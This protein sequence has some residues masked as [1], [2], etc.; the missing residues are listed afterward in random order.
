MLTATTLVPQSET[1]VHCYIDCAP[2]QMP[3]ILLV[4]KFE[5]RLLS[6]HLSVTPGIVQPHYG[7]FSLLVANPTNMPIVLPKRMTLGIATPVEDHESHLIENDIPTKLTSDIL[8]K[9]HFQPDPAYTIDLSRCQISDFQRDQLAHL[10][11]TFSDIFSRNQYDLG[12]CDVIKHKMTTTTNTPVTMRPTRVPHK[13]KQELNTQISNLIRAGVLKESNTNWLANLVFVQK[14][15]GTFRMCV[16]YRKL[17]AVT[18]NDIFPLPRID[19]ILER[20]GNCEYYTRLDLSQGFLQIKISEEMSNK[21]GIIVEDKCYQYTHLP[22]GLKNATSIFCRTMAQVLDGLQD[23]VCFYVDDVLIFTRSPDFDCHLHALRQVFQRFRKFNLKLSPH[24]CSFAMRTLD[25]LGHTLTKRGYTPGP[26]KLEAIKN[27]PIPQTVQQVRRFIGLAGFYRRFIPAFAKLSAPLTELTKKN[28]RFEWNSLRQLAFTELKRLLLCH[29]VLIFP[30]YDKDFHIFTDCSAIA[31]AGALMQ[32]ADG[33]KNSYQAISYCSRTLSDSERR[34]PIIQA[35]LATIVFALRAFKAYIFMTQCIVHTDHKPL[36]YVLKKPSAHPNLARW[37]IELQSYKVKIEFIK[38]EQN[39]VADAL[40]RIEDPNTTTVN[41]KDLD[42]IIDFPRCFSIPSANAIQHTPLFSIPVGHKFPVRTTTAHDHFLDMP[43]EQRKDPELKSIIDYLMSHALPPHMSL[44]ETQKFEQEANKY[45]IDTNGC[46]RITLESPKDGRQSRHCTPIVVPRSLRPLVFD[47]F[48]LSPLAGGH[49]S[50]KKVLHKA[51]PYYWP[52][53]ATDLYHWTK[54]CT[55]CQMRNNPKP[56]PHVPLFP[57]TSMAV[58]TNVGLDLC[59]P[60]TMTTKGHKYILNIICM[61]TKYVISIPVED[62]RSTTIAHAILTRCL[63]VYG[64]PSILLSD[65]AT[66][67]SSTFFQEF[68]N[69]LYIN[70]RYCTPYHSAGNG[71]VERTF[72]TFQNMLAKYITNQNSDFDEFLPFMTFCYN[73]SVNEMTGESPYFLMF[74]RDPRFAIE[75]V[76]KFQ[77]VPS[78]SEIDIDEY[79]NGLI[80][81][82]RLAWNIAHQYNLQAQARM[83]AIYDRKAQASKIKIGDRVL[84][85]RENVKPGHSKKFHLPWTGVYR[86]IDIRT[87]NA[88]LVSCTTPH[89]DP[90]KVHLNQIKKFYAI[91]GPACSLPTIPEEDKLALARLDAKSI[92]NMPGYSHP[93]ISEGQHPPQISSP[94]PDVPKSPYNLR[95]R[96]RNVDS[97]TKDP[98]SSPDSL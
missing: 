22:F 90:F 27:F 34:W 36:A 97:T 77:H 43:T 96:L 58:F 19:T 81:S 60:F 65:N 28:C 41:T 33:S 7:I 51:A 6:H 52:S 5:A 21:L 55:T 45:H 10:I 63:L 4:D 38:G 31:Q 3:S 79:K 69:L 91:D 50:F 84:L 8:H 92:T 76:L 82:L 89:A 53:K 24:K 80:T 46:L 42:D 9:E 15:D 98:V 35:E 56:Y 39:K 20:I 16:D 11:N 47:Y 95:P 74:G 67:F 1:F 64:T 86:V 44:Q 83:K 30:N 88:I 57:V 61:F 68:C 72:R 93:A 71:A 26:A 40:S 66:T 73:T 25:F 14:K 94:T 75:N 59:G 17:N 62:C 2:L 70:K 23:C 18:V 85:Q 12:S 87:P 54:A 32:L 37:I 49:L 29:P 78:Y 48:H 13:Y